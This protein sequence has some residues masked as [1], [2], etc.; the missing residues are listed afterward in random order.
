MEYDLLFTVIDDENWKEIAAQG[1]FKPKS[2]EELGYIKCIEEKDLERYVNL[3]SLKE[4]DLILVVIDPLRI[5][6][7]IKAGKEDGFNVI[8]IFGQLDLDAIIDKI[9]LKKSKKGNYSV[10]V[11]HYD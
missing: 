6:E 7:S 10:S 11:R 9:D 3:E 4:K 2:I 8:K 5:R 1:T